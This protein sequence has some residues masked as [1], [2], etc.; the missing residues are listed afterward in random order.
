MSGQPDPPTLTISDITAK[1]TKIKLQSKFDKNLVQYHIKYRKKDDDDDEKKVEWIEAKFKHNRDQHIINDLEMNTKYEIFA[2]F[3]VLENRIWSSYSKSKLF[4]TK[5]P[6]P[7]TLTISDITLTTTKIKFQSKYDKKLVRY[8]IKYRQKDGDDDEKKVEWNE[9][10]LNKNTDEYMINNLLKNT[11]YEIMG[12]FKLLSNSIWSQYSESKL[13]TTPNSVGPPFE[14]DPK[15]KA[16]SI[17]LSN[18]NKTASKASTSNQR[19]ISKNLLSGNEASSAEWEVTIRRESHTTH[20]YFAIGYVE[21]ATGREGCAI[22]YN[23]RECG[24]FLYLSQRWKKYDGGGS[25]SSPF[26]SKWKSNILKNGDRFKLIFDFVNRNCKVYLNEESV[27]TLKTNLPNKVYPAVS[28]GS[29][30]ILETT[31]W[32]VRG[33]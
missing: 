9:A 8:N 6:D 24:I 12:R 20:W 18:N 22:G 1:T 23:S 13:F 17:V 10:D 25:P 19:V 11:K 28:F 15:R 26:I 14:F 32:V 2:K 33:K 30:H 29:G 3:Q 31:Q 4:T 21:N 27:G 16:S 5:S 7:P